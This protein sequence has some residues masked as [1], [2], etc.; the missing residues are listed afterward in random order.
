MHDILHLL[1][2]PR[3]CVNTRTRARTRAHTDAHARAHADAHA[4]ATREAK[5][6]QSLSVFCSSC[7]L[8]RA[9]GT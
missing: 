1:C 3:N 5:G 8:R 9:A 2:N 4:H 7:R 6:Y